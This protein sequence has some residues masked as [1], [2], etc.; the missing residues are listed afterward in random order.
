LASPRSLCENY[1]VA[2]DMQWL[3]LLQV[4]NLLPN[5]EDGT[6]VSSMTALTSDQ[7]LVLYLSALVRSTIALHNL[8]NNKIENQ[9]ADQDKEKKDNQKKERADAKDKKA[10]EDKAA[11]AK[12]EE[13]KKA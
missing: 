12:K 5:I 2:I 7:M 11:D 6:F 13:A 3:T 9:K 4:F 10:V 8:I 1:V